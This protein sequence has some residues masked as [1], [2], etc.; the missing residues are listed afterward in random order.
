MFYI[1]ED[2]C[3]AVFTLTF[4]HRLTTNMIQ[5]FEETYSQLVAFYLTARLFIAVYYAIMA[6]VIPMVR[7]TMINQVVAILIPCAIW[8][9]SI[10][11][12]M[13]H[14]LIMIWIALALDLFATMVSIML[15]RISKKMSGR[16]HEFLDRIFEFYPAVNIEHKTERT[17]AF[18]TLIFGYSVVALLYQNTASFGVNAFYGKAVLG[19]I[20]AFCFNTLYFEIDG[21]SL[22]QHAIR[23]NVYSCES[24]LFTSHFHK[25][26]FQFTF[27]TIRLIEC[28]FL[29]LVWASAHLPFLLG[30]SLA[31]ASLSKLVVAHDCPDADEHNLT[32]VYAHKSSDHIDDGLRWFYCGGLGVALVSMGE[33]S[34]SLTPKNTHRSKGCISLSHIHRESGGIRVKKSYRLINRFAVSIV[35]VCL[36]LAQ[37]LNSMNL[38]STTTL[39]I[40]WVLFLELYG[41]SCARSSF[42]GGGNPTKYSAKCKMHKKDVEQAVKSGET[43]NVQELSHTGEKGLYELS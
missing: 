15:V 19:L 11:V 20:Q 21:D 39:L 26:S 23:R 6:F 2:R 8:I 31:G 24:S 16:L 25:L 28:P 12:E 43:V 41:A 35:I 18:V 38:I 9:G 27:S 33:S 17:N 4:F 3:L 32:E 42:F 22:W 14:R 30:Y 37:S 5:A 13:P 7:G 10:Y 36:P 1:K 34:I 40:A 29:A